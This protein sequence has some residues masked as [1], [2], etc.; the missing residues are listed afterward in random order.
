V[1]RTSLRAN[2][3]NQVELGRDSEPD[4]ERTTMPVVQLGDP[5]IEMAQ[6]ID[7]FDR[8]AYGLEQIKNIIKLFVVIQD[9]CME[10]SLLGSRHATLS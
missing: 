5:V 8:F 3:R 6:A 9:T 2:T 1:N 10:D 7:E 4:P